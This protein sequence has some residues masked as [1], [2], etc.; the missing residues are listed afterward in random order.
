MDNFSLPLTIYR[1]FTGKLYFLYDGEEYELR[2]PSNHIKYRAEML[3]DNII[4][5]EKFHSWIREDKLLETMISLGLWH[6]NT[7]NTISQ[8]E[9]KIENL[10]V[11]LYQNR[12]IIKQKNSIQKKI[13]MA[14]REIDNI[15]SIKNNFY[16][17]TL[18][19][20][21]GSI[22]NEFIICSTLYKNNKKVF[23]NN[24]NIRGSV[25]YTQFNN[26]V[27]E[28]N[29]H[30]LSIKNYKAIARS[31]LW[32]SYWNS[33]DK[34]SMFCQYTIDLTDE[35][36][37]LLNIS[38]MYDSIYEHPECPEDSVIEDDDMLDGW[39]ILQRRESQKNKKQQSISN[40]NK[41]KNASE[42]FVM[43]D[44]KEDAKNVFDLNTDEGRFLFKEKM[45]YIGANTGQEVE[46]YSLPDVQR[47]LISQAKKLK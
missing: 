28:I 30:I 3:Y 9:K 5:E 39:M 8:L 44:S 17:N 11:E 19:G 38:K 40:N 34:N 12:L 33:S 43:T 18:E 23:S 22:K 29:K 37:S 41:I 21:A 31:Q 20:Y 16:T 1:I 27:T 46:D 36:R 47:D 13:D 14:Y 42:V 24:S 7:D 6:P 26:I 2:S 35:Q 15:S 45:S 4:N 10:K 32:K 25:S